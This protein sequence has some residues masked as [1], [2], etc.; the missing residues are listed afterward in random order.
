MRPESFAAAAS[1][2]DWKGAK[3]YAV[4]IIDQPGA[5]SWPIV[6]TTFILLPKDP[7][8]ATRG[9]NVIKFF[10]WAYKSG[11]AIATSLDYIP[12]PEAVQNAVRAS[13]AEV[14]G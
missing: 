10:D 13:W 6:S 4:D 2:A 8:D 11:S 7:K 5:T 12:L 9:A 3:N 1:N 14:K